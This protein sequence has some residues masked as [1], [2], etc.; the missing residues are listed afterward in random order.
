VDPATGRS[1][2]QALGRLDARLEVLTEA[3]VAG[4]DFPFLPVSFGR[5]LLTSCYRSEQGNAIFFGEGP[6]GLKDVRVSKAFRH[7]ANMRA[8]FD[9]VRINEICGCW[10]WHVESVWFRLSP[11]HL[12]DHNLYRLRACPIPLHIRRRI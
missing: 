2:I 3:I 6:I 5:K 4:G 11:V 10:S 9:Q 12:W 1:G 7:V 8:G